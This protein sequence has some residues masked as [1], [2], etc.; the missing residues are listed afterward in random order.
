MAFEINPFS[1]LIPDE[2]KYPECSACNEPIDFQEDFQQCGCPTGS[3]YLCQQCI[4]VD[5]NSDD[6]QSDEFC[7]CSNKCDVYEPELEIFYDHPDDKHLLNNYIGEIKITQLQNMIENVI[8]EYPIYFDIITHVSDVQIIKG[9]NKWD[10]KFRICVKEEDNILWL[11]T[12]TPV[13]Q[14]LFFNESV[15]KI[16]EIYHPK[17]DEYISK[18]NKI[19]VTL[20]HIKGVILEKK[21]SGIMI[22]ALDIHYTIETKRSVTKQ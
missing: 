4:D 13:I 15:D 20:Y 8:N 21:E 14:C 11:N 5:I 6:S 22:N 16:I 3:S 7:I 12:T 10:T 18:F 9:K 17:S 2:L 1:I 19:L